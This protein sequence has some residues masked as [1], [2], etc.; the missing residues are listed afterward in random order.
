MTDRC[1]NITFPQVRLQAVITLKIAIQN[2]WITLD[3]PQKHQKIQHVPRPCWLKFN[4]RGAVQMGVIDPLN[5][6]VGF[7]IRMT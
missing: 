4:I 1:K 2:R 6:G 3:M 5:F 7:R